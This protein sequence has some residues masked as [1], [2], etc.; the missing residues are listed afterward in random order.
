M[1]EESSASFGLNQK[2]ILKISKIFN[3]YP[4][5]SQVFIY[6]SRA[7]GNFK[8]GSD[9]DLAIKGDELSIDLLLKIE[10]A[11]DEL[12]LPYTFDISLYD[13]ISNVEL[14]EHIDRVGKPI[15]DKRVFNTL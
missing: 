4:Q 11:L 2:N 5:I 12:L 9:I 14:L 6:G 7:K 3:S 13:H 1:N 10:V 15:Y 8:K